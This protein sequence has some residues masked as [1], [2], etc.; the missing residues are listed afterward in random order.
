[1]R[2]PFPSPAKIAAPPPPG[3]FRLRP[4]RRWN[5]P[6]GRP[7]SRVEKFG[8][9]GLPEAIR[10]KLITLIP[11]MRR[12]GVALTNSLAEADELVQDACERMLRHSGQLRDIGRFDAWAYSIMRHLWTDRLRARKFRDHDTLET[13]MEITGEDGRSVVEGRIAL[14]L[15]R[16]CL[17]ELPAEQRAVLM[18]VCVDGLS[19]REAADTMGVAI[20]T[21]MSRLSRGRQALAARLVEADQPLSSTVI[22][23]PAGRPRPLS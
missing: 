7:V 10:A 16:R 2:I 14:D 8:D 5:R 4:S 9:I 11:R 23:W 18:L 6:A 1:M 22:A 21:V 3:G 13:A 15:V 12:F 20:G 17:D 19:Y